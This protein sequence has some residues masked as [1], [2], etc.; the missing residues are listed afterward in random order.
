MRLTVCC[1]K[2]R[3]DFSA[4]PD[5]FVKKKGTRQNAPSPNSNVVGRLPFP[6]T[7]VLNPLQWTILF[8]EGAYPLLG[9]A[10]R[11]VCLRCGLQ[12]VLAI[13]FLWQ[14]RKEYLAFRGLGDSGGAGAVR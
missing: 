5:N 10:W 13:E 7:S 3:H 8:A 6:V 12:V 11:N 2:F 1:R 4:L 9:G 14:G